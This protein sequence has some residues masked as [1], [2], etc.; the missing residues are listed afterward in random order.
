VARTRQLDPEHLGDHL[1]RLFGA[2]WALCGSREDAEDL[3]Q[4]TYARV[5]AKPRWLRRDDDLAYLLRA[6]RNTFSALR[7]ASDRRPRSAL[8]LA[9][10]DRLEDRTTVAPDA[11]VEAGEVHAAI[12]ALPPAFRDAV[13]AIDVLGL[14]YRQ[15]ARALR[16]REATVTTRLH[17]GRLRLAAALSAGESVGERAA[18]APGG[19]REKRRPRHPASG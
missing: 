11:A 7:R 1:D 15:A 18:R 5:L 6:L 16:V 3:A 13:T 17:R 8:P 10:L 19:E 12:A 9:A 4:E 14:S 2:A